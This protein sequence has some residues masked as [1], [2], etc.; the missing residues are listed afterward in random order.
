[1]G[2]L[3][4]HNWHRADL[5]NPIIEQASKL[6]KCSK[7]ELKT[8]SSPPT[9]HLYDKKTTDRAIAVDGIKPGTPAL[10][11]H[12]LHELTN[13]RCGVTL[14]ETRTDPP[15]QYIF[16]SF[17]DCNGYL[18]TFLVARN[19][20]IFRLFRYF[21]RCQTKNNLEE[22]PILND[23]LIDE[24][25]KQTIHFLIAADDIE[26]FGVR[27]RRGILLHGLP[28]NGKT[29][30]CQWIRKL[31]D[32][33][34][35]SWSRVAA[36]QILEA[37][38]NSTL[39]TLVSGTSVTFFDDID[40]SFLCRQNS[41]SARLA[42]ALLAALDGIKKNSHVIRIFT[43]NEVVSSI[44]SAFLRPGRIDRIFLFDKP[45]CEMRRK[46]IERW[47]E[48]ITENVGICNIVQ[49]TKDF[50]FAETEAI[51]SLL[52]TRYLF[53]GGVWDLRE[54]MEDYRKYTGTKEIASA[55]F[56]SSS[57]R[58]SKS[59]VSRDVRRNSA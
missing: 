41:E 30:A 57:E 22:P 21:K 18:V 34:N 12:G 1:M 36:G 42:C 47:P 50:S 4:T 49:E 39:D 51:R 24:L 54:A 29:M 2:R 52:V 38:G 7:D 45:T 48:E 25:L 11:S 44:D 8:F 3:A 32:D 19:G 9:M 33:H 59:S 13:G 53:D 27:I 23:G 15:I 5:L 26:K 20:E 16:A 46:L 40:M 35:I 56:N 17:L 55:G 10:M 28:G 31:C 58:N 14:F 37:F 6:L 43:T